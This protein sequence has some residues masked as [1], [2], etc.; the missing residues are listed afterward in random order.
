MIIIFQEPHPLF[1][2][3]TK[4]LCVSLLYLTQGNKLILHR[5]KK[6]EKEKE[7]EAWHVSSVC[8]YFCFPN[9][10]VQMRYSITFIGNVI[11]CLHVIVTIRESS[12]IVYHNIHIFVVDF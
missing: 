10:S 6:K 3:S 8:L 2:I 11:V 5:Q 9:H 7:K 12:H 4:L 1:Y